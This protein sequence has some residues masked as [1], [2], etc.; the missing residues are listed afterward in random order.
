MTELRIPWADDPKYSEPVVEIYY[1]AMKPLRDMKINDKEL[2]KTFSYTN[3]LVEKS[4][5][6]LNLP[7][8]CPVVK[9]YK[10][11]NVI[12][13]ARPRYLNGG[14]LCNIDVFEDCTGLF[15]GI[16]FNTH[17]DND[18]LYLSLGSEPNIDSTIVAL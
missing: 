1:E 17:P 7:F 8:S 12:G 10:I 5:P 3:V 18:M 14:I 2:Q 16:C 15:P 6:E 4:E 11:D 13:I 9:D